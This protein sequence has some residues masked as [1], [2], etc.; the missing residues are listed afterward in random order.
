MLKKAQAQESS[1]KDMPV[2]KRVKHTYALWHEHLR[3]FG[4]S[5]GE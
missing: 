1:D 2:V 3:K 5:E 4:S